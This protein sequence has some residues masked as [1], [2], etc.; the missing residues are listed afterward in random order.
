MRNTARRSPSRKTSK[1]YF[2][3]TIT[4]LV[5]NAIAMQHVWVEMKSGLLPTA[6]NDLVDSFS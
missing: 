3:T 4:Q 2:Y 1:V 5:I 6:L